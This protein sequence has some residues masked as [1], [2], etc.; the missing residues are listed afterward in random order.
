LGFSDQIPTHNKGH[1]METMT[2]TCKCDL[3]DLFPAN[4]SGQEE[5]LAHLQSLSDD[6]I[7]TFIWQLGSD[8]LHDYPEIEK[9]PYIFG[10]FLLR[11]LELSDSTPDEDNWDVLWV[12]IDHHVNVYISHERESPDGSESADY[13]RVMIEII[14]LLH[15]RIAKDIEDGGLLN[16]AEDYFIQRVTLDR[17]DLLWAISSV[18]TNGELF[19]R[20][21]VQQHIGWMME[22]PV[23]YY[24]PKT[25]G[26]L[27]PEFL[28]VIVKIAGNLASVEKHA[29]LTLMMLPLM[30]VI[31]K[32]DIGPEVSAAMLYSFNCFVFGH[33]KAAELTDS[34]VAPFLN[35]LRE[36]IEDKTYIDQKEFLIGFKSKARM[37]RQWGMTQEAC[38]LQLERTE[39]QLPKIKK[40]GVNKRHKT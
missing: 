3:E 24:A 39:E 21:Q 15:R 34:I 23:E 31:L 30:G 37:T 25:N 28:K 32:Y 4:V 26:A 29:D 35:A 5:M 10:A 19:E 14:G 8:T 1:M 16:S 22:I 7:K 6:K 11:I 36:C 2:E 33:P 17:M 12:K 9:R 38:R 27:I 20:D 18:G 13:K 40:T